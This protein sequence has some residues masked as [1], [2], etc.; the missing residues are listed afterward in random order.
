MLIP[1]CGSCG[2]N[3]PLEQSGICTA[4]LAFREV[5]GCWP[6]RSH[7]VWSS[8]PEPKPR[9]VVIRRSPR[10]EMEDQIFG[11]E[12]VYEELTHRGH[13]IGRRIA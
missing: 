11:A 7:L 3:K 6:E 2:K 1:F 8:R 13:S 12:R 5:Y 10:R 9:R 4:C